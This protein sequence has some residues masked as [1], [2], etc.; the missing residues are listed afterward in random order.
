MCGAVPWLGVSPLESEFER[1]C[2]FFL[3][4]GLAWYLSASVCV[5]VWVW[6]CVCVCVCVRACVR[7][8]V[9]VCVCVCVCVCARARVRCVCVCV[10]VHVYVDSRT[11]A[12]FE[13]KSYIGMLPLCFQCILPPS[14][15]STSL[16]VFDLLLPQLLQT[17]HA[18]RLQLR[19]SICVSVFTCSFVHTLAQTL[20]AQ[21]HLALQ[22]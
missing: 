7:A 10:H 20:V 9:R 3:L 17:S 2:F 6:V 4:N 15:D 1:P 14:F 11:C 8:C 19:M 5:C 12:C 16:P 18:R 13:P 22:K 21:V